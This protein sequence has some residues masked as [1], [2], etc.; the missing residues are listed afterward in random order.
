MIDRE[1]VMKIGPVTHNNLIVFTNLDSDKY[2]KQEEVN[3]KIQRTE[4]E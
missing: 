1:N 4:A 2:K 3:A